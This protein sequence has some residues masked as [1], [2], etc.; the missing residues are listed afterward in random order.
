MSKLA[1]VATTL[2]AMSG[3]GQSVFAEET[4]SEPRCVCG[5]ST[6]ADVLNADRATFPDSANA[7]ANERDS[8]IDG[9]ART[10]QTSSRY[11]RRSSAGDARSTAYMVITRARTPWSGPT[12]RMGVAF[13]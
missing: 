8:R 4:I 7:S 3:G 6:G 13:A 1:I 10:P 12:S 2:L 5:L 9:R 11:H